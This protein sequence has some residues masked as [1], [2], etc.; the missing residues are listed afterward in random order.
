MSD[1]RVSQYW[2]QPRPGDRRS[3]RPQLEWPD[4]FLSELAQSGDV[5][6]AC[7]VAGVTRRAALELRWNTRT[8]AAAWEQALS[9]SRDRRWARVLAAVLR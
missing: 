5:L 2:L 4:R 9:Q 1:R 3:D 8:F 6:T 7:R